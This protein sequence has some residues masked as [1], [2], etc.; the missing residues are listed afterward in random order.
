MKF[1]NVSGGDTVYFS[2]GTNHSAGVAVLL[3]IFN[4]DVLKSRLFQRW[5]SELSC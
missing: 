4:F 1:G 3:N 5:G 2:H